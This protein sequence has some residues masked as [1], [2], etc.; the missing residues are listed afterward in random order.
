MPPTDAAAS[1]T[2]LASTLPSAPAK[3]SSFGTKAAG[4]W[5]SVRPSRSLIWLAKMIVAMP[6]VKPTVTG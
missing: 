2:V 5:A 4:S 6:A 1:S 3:A